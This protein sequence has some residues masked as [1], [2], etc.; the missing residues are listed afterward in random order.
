MFPLRQRERATLNLVR[1]RLNLGL[2]VAD[3]AAETELHSR[4]LQGL[5]ISFDNLSVGIDDLGPT[6]AASVR[7]SDEADR[8]LRAPAPDHFAVPSVSNIGSEHEF[9]RTEKDVGRENQRSCFRDV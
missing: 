4:V 2:D 6:L 8:H 7:A 1:Y 5:S 9:F 3:D